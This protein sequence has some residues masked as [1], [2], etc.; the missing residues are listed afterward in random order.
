L[1]HF[2]KPRRFAANS[3]PIRSDW[4]LRCPA[5]IRSIASE[6]DE[7]VEQDEKEE[8]RVR[9]AGVANFRDSYFR[10]SQMKRAQVMAPITLLRGQ[11][12]SFYGQSFS[13]FVEEVSYEFQP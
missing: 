12:K 8:G 2:R 10:V 6:S 5:S 1:A 9:W 11:T 4:G 7:E 13:Y 3:R